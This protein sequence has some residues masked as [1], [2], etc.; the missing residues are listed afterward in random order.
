MMNREQM[1][2]IIATAL[3]SYN[4]LATK[5][6]P[7]PDYIANAIAIRQPKEEIVTLHTGET[8]IGEIIAA[9][10]SS[11]HTYGD[12]RDTAYE[13]EIEHERTLRKESEQ[14]R[15][16]AVCRADMAEKRA[17]RAEATLAAIKVAMK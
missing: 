5:G 17:E 8:V 13:T 7:L 4:W 14:R 10:P 9:N 11:V 12:A 6:S 16:T 15:Q 2:E 1:R 3:R